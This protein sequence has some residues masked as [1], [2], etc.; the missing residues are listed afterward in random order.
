MCKTQKWSSSKIN[1]NTIQL[2]SGTPIIIL[3][4]LAARNQKRVDAGISQI[5]TAWPTSLMEHQ[6]PEYGGGRRGCEVTGEAEWKD[7]VGAAQEIM[8]KTE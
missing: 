5:Y 6:E 4:H 3:K 7:S 2:L 1:W 8:F